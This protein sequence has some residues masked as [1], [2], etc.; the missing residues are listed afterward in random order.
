MP[1]AACSLSAMTGVCNRQT[2]RQ[3]KLTR[4]RRFSRP[5]TQN[6]AKEVITPSNTKRSNT[7][8][9]KL[10][11][12]P[13]KQT[14]LTRKTTSLIASRSQRNE[15]RIKSRD[16]T[17]QARS[18]DWPGRTKK[19]LFYFGV[20]GLDLTF[21]RINSS[22]CLIRIVRWNSQSCPLFNHDL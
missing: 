22:L 6:L 21:V 14:K 13:L 1:A 9:P 8:E 5:H 16:R 19:R 4:E 15:G 18:S 3:P 20:K 2:R 7:Q 12:T 10:P 11:N 17:G